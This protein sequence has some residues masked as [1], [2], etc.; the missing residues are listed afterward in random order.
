[1]R[2]NPSRA[3][4]LQAWHLEPAGPASPRSVR[5]SAAER[6]ELERTESL[7]CALLARAFCVTR[8]LKLV[9]ITPSLYGHCG[10]A[11]SRVPTRMLVLTGANEGRTPEDGLC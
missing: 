3:G 4:S 11:R 9:A 7:Y 5:S 6:C 2:L 8:A 1:M 10:P